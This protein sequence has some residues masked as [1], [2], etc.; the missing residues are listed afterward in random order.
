MSAVKTRKTRKISAS[1]VDDEM[2]SRAASGPV[3]SVCSESGSD[4]KVRP[5]PPASKDK[6]PDFAGGREDSD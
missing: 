6:L 4:R 5:S 1:D 2:R 3:I